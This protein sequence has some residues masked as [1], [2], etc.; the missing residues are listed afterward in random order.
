MMS[1]M[2]FFD[3]ALVQALIAHYGYFL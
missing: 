1:A 2:T 3:A